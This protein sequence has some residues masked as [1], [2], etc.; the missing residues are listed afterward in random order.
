MAEASF[1]VGFLLMPTE[2]SARGTAPRWTE[3]LAMVRRAEELGYDT[4][5]LPDHLIIDVPRPGSRPEGTWEG[6]SLA[7][8]LAATT[9]RIKIGLLVSCT[10]FRNPALLAKMADTVDEISGGRLILGLGAGWCELEF[11]SFGYPFDHL[12]G[13]FEEALQIIAPLLRTGHVDFEGKYYSARDC[14]LR[15]RG[16]RPEGPPILIGSMAGPRMLRL[17][18]TYADIWNRDFN[19]FSPETEPYSAADLAASQ[20]RIDAVCQEVG[21][22]PSTLTRTAGVWVDLPIAPS[23][24]WNAV[25]GT[26]EEIAARLRLFAEAGYSS[27]EAWLHPGTIEGV[28]A[29]APVVEM[30]KG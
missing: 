30:L 5:W 12:V 2:D 18:A 19:A 22:D 14:E 4:V 16:P 1:G 23:R 21:R 13:R 29:F 17:V 8:A 11:R 28:E 3:M 20:T 15:P 7:S 9:E 26:P 25:S 6:W 10:A 24:G 27:V